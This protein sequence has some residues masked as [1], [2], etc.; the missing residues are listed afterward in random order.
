LLGPERSDHPDH[1]KQ[2]PAIADD[3]ESVGQFN[4]LMN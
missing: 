1:G 4:E 2:D 3:F